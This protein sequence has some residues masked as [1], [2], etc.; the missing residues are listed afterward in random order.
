MPQFISYLQHKVTPLCVLVANLYNFIIKCQ[1]NVIWLQDFIKQRKSQ[2]KIS[3]VRKCSRRAVQFAIKKL[4]ETWVL[5]NKEN[6]CWKHVAMKHHGR[7][8]IRKSVRY[9]KNFFWSSV[10]KYIEH[11]LSTQAEGRRLRKAEFNIM[12]LSCMGADSFSETFV[13]KSR[14]NMSGQK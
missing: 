1:K 3:Q 7:K 11:N 13:F 2:V 14:M 4:T 6:M 5:E 10:R 12:I 8:L 9:P